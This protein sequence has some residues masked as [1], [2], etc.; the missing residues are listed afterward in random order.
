[1]K[2][3]TFAT[4]IIHPICYTCS[5]KP[6][7]DG[8]QKWLRNLPVDFLSHLWEFYQEEHNETTLRPIGRVILFDGTNEPLYDARPIKL[9]TETDVFNHCLDLGL[10]TTQAL[11][12]IQWKPRD[13]RN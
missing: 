9:M 3:G 8:F 10:S 11:K 12:I 1:M 4:T 2:E 5:M 13:T 6:S 7:D